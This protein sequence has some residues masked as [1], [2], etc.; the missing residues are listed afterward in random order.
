[1]NSKNPFRQRTPDN[2]PEPGAPGTGQDVCPACEGTGKKVD[3]ASGKR[4]GETCERC[5]GTGTVV[6]PIG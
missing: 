4:S 1:M 5:D 2:D 6:Q 3:K